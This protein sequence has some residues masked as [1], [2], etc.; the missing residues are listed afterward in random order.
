MIDISI[1]TKVYKPTYYNWGVPHCRDYSLDVW[2]IPSKV[3]AYYVQE[4]IMFP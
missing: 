2:K 1:L 3:E 4:P